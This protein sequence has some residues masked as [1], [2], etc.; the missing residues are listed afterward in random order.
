[1]SDALSATQ[2]ALGREQRRSALGALAAAAAHG[3]G[4]PLGTI[5]VVAKEIARDLPPDS[6]L[7]GDI[8]L[9]ISQSDRCREILAGLAMR[10]ESGEHEDT[11]MP[12]KALVES[13]AEP[14]RIAGIG[15]A[16]AFAPGAEAGADAEPGGGPLLPS[17]PEI[18]HGLGNLV[19]NAF[20]FARSTV[21]V[22]VTPLHGRLTVSIADD[23][24]GIDP[25]LVGRLGEPYLSGGAQGRA[26]KSGVHMGLGVFIAQTL[27]EQSGATLAFRNRLQGGAEAI[28]SWDAAALERLLR[29]HDGSGQ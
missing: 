28:V 1:M 3:L 19:E 27:L 29:Q 24:P 8:D 23:G 2:M 18:V 16:V 20:E 14:Y 25:G 13:V 6:A 17:S 12:A 9:L 22:T 4:T 15:L 7:R 21:R 11:P 10:P 5:A 26:G